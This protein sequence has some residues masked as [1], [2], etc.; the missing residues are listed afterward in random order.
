MSGPTHNRDAAVGP[1]RAEIDSSASPSSNAAPDHSSGITRPL[2]TVLAYYVLLIGVWTAA[3]G[4]AKMAGL[5]SQSLRVQTLYWTLAKLLIWLAPIFA[6]LARHRSVSIARYLSIERLAVGAKIGALYGLAFVLVSFLSDVWTR[7]FGAPTIDSGLMNA[8]LIAPPFEELVFRGFILTTL[9]QAGVR[10][11]P[12]NVVSA[13][14]FLGLHIPGW[15]FM[16]S[17]KTSD[18]AALVG[19]NL[20]GVVA[21]VAKQRS[22]SLYA[23]IVVHFLNNLY[24]S[25]VR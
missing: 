24:G 5:G 21:G 22:G 3:W 1:V 6:I 25:F 20:V 7:S 15:Y 18:I 11:W 19:I 23:A 12:A 17:P 9:Q 2:G 10:F 16:G 13:L 4:F 14:M 8:L